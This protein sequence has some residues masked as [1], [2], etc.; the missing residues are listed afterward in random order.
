MF[1]FEIPKNYAHAMELDNRNSNTRWKNFTQ[2]EL[3]QLYDYSTF[4]DMGKFP[5]NS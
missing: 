3:N 4:K 5:K 1:G 2:L